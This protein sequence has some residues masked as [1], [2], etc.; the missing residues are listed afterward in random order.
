MSTTPPP[1]PPKHPPSPTTS[2]PDDDIEDSWTTWERSVL[3]K[4][5]T[6]LK[7]TR[8]PSSL[9]RLPNSSKPLLPWWPQERLRNEAATLAF[10][11][12]NTT[13]PVPACRLYSTE[14]GLLHLEMARITT[15]I[16]LM[17]VAPEARAAAIAAVDAQ[18]ASDILP[19]LRRLRRGYIGSVDSTLP[20]FPP[21]RIYG[22]DRRVWPRISS[23]SGEEE[24]EFVF[25]HNDL[26]PQNIFV[27]PETSFRIVGI[28][29]WEFAGFF[30]REFELPLWREFE[31]EGGKRMYDEAR[32]RDL[33]FFGLT[34]GD[35]K[36]DRGSSPPP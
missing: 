12:S 13:I 4:T 2:A 27:D 31:W 33:G 26:A 7:S 6:V 17:D 19:Q 20:V 23:S 14:D 11:A 9:P 3:I 29:D 22:L 15:G 34:E 30:P 5:H 25:C 10:I 18:M 24:E 28:I 35:L 16:L 8:P 36:D 32:G 21:S 1:P